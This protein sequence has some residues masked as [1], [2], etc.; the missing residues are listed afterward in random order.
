MNYGRYAKIKKCKWVSRLNLKYRLNFTLLIPN[1]FMIGASSHILP[2]LGSIDSHL[3]NFLASYL[4]SHFLKLTYH[5]SVPESFA[6]FKRRSIR[7]EEEV[8]YFWRKTFSTGHLCIESDAS[9]V[10]EFR[11]TFSAFS[12]ALFTIIIEKLDNKMII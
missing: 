10:I 8:L 4:F 11:Y 9:F 3:K 5:H 7:E 2:L 6:R 1:V 12:S